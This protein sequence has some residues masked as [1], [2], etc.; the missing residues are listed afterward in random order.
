MESIPEGLVYPN[1]TLKPSI[2][3]SWLQLIELAEHSIDIASFYWSLQGN[4]VVPHPS[5]WKVYI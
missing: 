4:D 2:F 5:A 1:G 3:D